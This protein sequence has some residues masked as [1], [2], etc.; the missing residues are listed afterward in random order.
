MFNLLC[1]SFEYWSHWYFDM[2]L[3]GGKNVNRCLESL[4]DAGRSIRIPTRAYKHILDLSTHYN[5]TRRTPIRISFNL[6]DKKGLF[7]RD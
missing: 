6:V 3:L 1:V 5:I 7:F 2:I 4:I